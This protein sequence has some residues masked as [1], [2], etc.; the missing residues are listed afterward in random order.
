MHRAPILERVLGW[1]RRTS[2]L[3][4]ILRHRRDAPRQ[5]L[6]GRLR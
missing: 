5:Y 2:R 1:K 6:I 4:T 3:P